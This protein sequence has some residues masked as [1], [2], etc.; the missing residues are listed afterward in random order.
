MSGLT[1][2]FDQLL[3]EIK[4]FRNI[5]QDFILPET[6]HI[7]REF[8]DRLRLIREK[9]I[10]D[11]KRWEIRADSPLRTVVSQGEYEP[12]GRSGGYKVYAEIS[13]LWEIQCPD[14][15][16]KKKAP[17]ETFILNGKASTKVKLFREMENK[18]PQLVGVWNTE[19]GDDASPGC[20]FHTAV[21]QDESCFMFPRLL[22]IPRFPTIL[23]TPCTVIEFVLAEL[24]QSK[25]QRH[26]AKPSDDMAAWRNAQLPRFEKLLDWHAQVLKGTTTSPWTHLKSSK[27][28][29]DLFLS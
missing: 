16:T 1:F 21:L 25:W 4:A 27:P 23:I 3:R 5:S 29:T 15:K 2:S 26:A 8:E 6:G 11:P 7:L 28:A 14:E 10:R 12:G 18:T 24:F 9:K 17:Q 13:S 19:V 22:T 20:H